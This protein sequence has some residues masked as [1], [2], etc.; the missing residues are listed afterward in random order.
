MWNGLLSV[1]QNFFKVSFRN[2]VY[3][4]ITKITLGIYGRR[5]YYQT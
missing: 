1:P 5:N 3:F 4:K 2:S